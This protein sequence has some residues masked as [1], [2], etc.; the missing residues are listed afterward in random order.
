VRVL[1]IDP[2]SRFTGYGV[3]DVVP[4]ALRHVGHGLIRA[5][6]G[7]ALEARL[8]VIF[9][10]LAQAIAVYRP[11]AV[12]VEG[13]FS[14][15]NARSALVLGHARGVAL[16]A[17]AQAG[18]PVFEYSPAQVKRSV[19]AGGAAGKDAVE[20]MVRTVLTIGPLERS[21]AA[22]ALAVAIC[23]CNHHRAPLPAGASRR[24]RAQ[25]EQ[26]LSPAYRKFGAAR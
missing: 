20:R 21:D 8:E 6:T 7:C 2:G 16:L 24:G 15:K 22:D 10:A 19:G 17:A 12:A 5:D 3:V 1:G 26:R 25:F 18:L 9:R 14:F 13:L 4:R 23:H 11:A